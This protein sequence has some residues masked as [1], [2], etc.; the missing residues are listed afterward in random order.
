LIVRPHACSRMA[1]RARV[2]LPLGG[3]EAG[4]AW[5]QGGLLREGQ[6]FEVWMIQLDLDMQPN[7]RIANP[8]RVTHHERLNLPEES[9][10]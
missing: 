5:H 4:R 6:L 9:P 10:R 2:G 8:R 3:R 1:A 7:K